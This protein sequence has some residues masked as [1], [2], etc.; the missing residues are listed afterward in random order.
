M[1]L[2]TE[3]SGQVRSTSR[4]SPWMI[5]SGDGNMSEILDDFEIDDG[6]PA[7][8]AAAAGGLPKTPTRV[9]ARAAGEAARGAEFKRAEPHVDY[10]E[11]ADEGE[12]PAATLRRLTTVS[13]AER[14][15]AHY[16]WLTGNADRWVL[17]D[18]CSPG[19]VANEITRLLGVQ[20]DLQKLDS[21]ADKG[22]A[23]ASLLDA[24]GRGEPAVY[25]EQPGASGEWKGESGEGEEPE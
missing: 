9:Q 19:M 12:L 7:A 5:E 16:A 1:K 25:D 11:G 3:P 24:L 15:D 6:G 2:A 8:K 21:G 17:N 4:Q 20:F 14:I 13:L 22:E 18:K 23:L 10:F